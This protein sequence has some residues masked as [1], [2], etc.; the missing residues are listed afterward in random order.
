[1]RLKITIEPNCSGSMPNSTAIGRKMGVV[2]SSA[3]VGSRIMPRPSSTTLMMSR[4]TS[5]SVV[6][7]TSVSATVC[8]TRSRARI[9]LSRADAPMMIM[10][11]AVTIRGVAE[12]EHDVVAAHGPIGQRQAEHVERP[13]AGSLGRR[14]VAAEDAAQD[15]HGRPH[16][17]QG[18]HERAPDAAPSRRAHP[19]TAASGAPR[20]R[21]VTAIASVIRMAGMT[22][23]ANRAPVDT[24]ATD[25]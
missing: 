11:W 3:D 8:G 14:E 15:D 25:A 22:A 2:I 19:R 1:M 18:P 7:P 20:R 16:R 21:R 12:D 5:G 23:A 24:A 4:N 9:Q 6:N 10:I 13:D 17:R